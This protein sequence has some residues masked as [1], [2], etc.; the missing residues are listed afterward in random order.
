MNIIIKPSVYSPGIP[1]TNINLSIVIH[2][3]PGE[4][5]RQKREEAVKNLLALLHE[6]QTDEKYLDEGE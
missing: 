6:W 3:Q 2:S 4:Y 5:H 1:A